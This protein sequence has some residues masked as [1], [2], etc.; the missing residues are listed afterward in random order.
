M[1]PSSSSHYIP[2]YEPLAQKYTPKAP[3]F[4]T[5]KPNKTHHQT[6]IYLSIYT[7][8]I[9]NFHHHHHHRRERL[10]FWNG[11]CNS[12]NWVFFLWKLGSFFNGGWRLQ[13]VGEIGAFSSSIWGQESSEVHAHDEERQWREGSVCP[14]CGRH[15]QYHWQEAIQSASRQSH[16]FTLSGMSCTCCCLV[17]LFPI[18]KDMFWNSWEK[19]SWGNMFWTDSY[20]YHMHVG[21]LF[22][23]VWIE[24]KQ[25]Q[26]TSECSEFWGECS[27]YN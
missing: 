4:H 26:F 1:L 20:S 2:S 10:S 21:S 23:L 24:W 16:C 17:A 22:G 15:P 12:R 11:F 14:Y 5:N 19:R 18:F 3:I 27:V 7:S 8:E 13:R 25:L 6:P 9:N